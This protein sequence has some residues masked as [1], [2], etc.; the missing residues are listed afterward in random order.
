MTGVAYA[1]QPSG[2]QANVEQSSLQQTSP[3]QSKDASGG[4]WTYG[5]YGDMH[6]H[7][8]FYHPSKD[9]GSS[10]ELD[11][12]N[13]TSPECDGGQTSQASKWCLVDLPWTLD[14]YWYHLS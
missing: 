2:P 10:C 1:N 9:H 8:D 13:A 14:K 3:K 11:G 12:Q 4:T 5:N 6:I 7:S